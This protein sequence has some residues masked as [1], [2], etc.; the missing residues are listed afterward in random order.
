MSL[1]PTLFSIPR[2]RSLSW[3][4]PRPSAPYPSPPLQLLPLRPTPL[5]APP[6]HP[7]RYIAAYEAETIAFIESIEQGPSADAPVT[8]EDG[9]V[10]LAMAIAAGKSAEEQRWVKISEILPTIAEKAP[11]REAPP[12]ERLGAFMRSIAAFGR[13]YAGSKAA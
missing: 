4:G 2:S 12:R 5:D 10:A 3:C 8:G 13:D 9:V 11:P 1:C 7:P 6:P